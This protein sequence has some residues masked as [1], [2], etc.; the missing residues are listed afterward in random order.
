VVV[1]GAAQVTSGCWFN[2]G[3]E[4]DKQGRPKRPQGDER[5]PDDAGIV[6]DDAIC[7]ERTYFC[8]QCTMGMWSGGRAAATV[9]ARGGGVMRLN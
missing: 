6:I 8:K 5:S 3:D 9:G 1:I 2:G 7:F 4:R